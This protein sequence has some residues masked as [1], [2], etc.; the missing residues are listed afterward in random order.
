M[1]LSCLHQLNESVRF[2]FVIKFEECPNFSS[3]L[4]DVHPLISG[5]A[6]RNS[7]SQRYFQICWFT[8]FWPVHGRKL[9]CLRKQANKLAGQFTRLTRLKGPF[10]QPRSAKFFTDYVSNPIM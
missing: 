5:F 6:L 10:I 3:E 2:L 4:N 8:E 7:K 9:R 1:I